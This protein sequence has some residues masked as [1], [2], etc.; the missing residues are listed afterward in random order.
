MLVVVLPYMLS[1]HLSRIVVSKPARMGLVQ[2]P[3]AASVLCAADEDSVDV[4][5]LSKEQKDALMEAAKSSNFYPML[6]KPGGASAQAWAAIKVSYPALDGVDDAVLASS[7]AETKVTGAGGR[8]PSEAGKTGLLPWQSIQK[9]VVSAFDPLL[10]SQKVAL[11]RAVRTGLYTRELEAAGGVSAEAWAS[12][13]AASPDLGGLTVEVLDAAAAELLAVEDRRFGAAPSTS[14]SNGDGTTSTSGFGAGAA[15]LLLV[16]A[17]V[18][19]GFSGFK[20]ADLICSSNPT[21]VACVEKQTR[22]AA[23]PSR[24][25]LADA[26]EQVQNNVGRWVEK[27]LPK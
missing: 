18:A 27:N 21:Y 25:K 20:P 15:P 6:N 17:A 8:R 16:A 14:A 26:N 13:A 9:P 7:F 1:W 11:V 24:D 19:L 10:I 4:L 22:D 23:P 2:A 3:R 12:I 5:S